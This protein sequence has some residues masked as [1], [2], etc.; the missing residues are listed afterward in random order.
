MLLFS[1]TLELLIIP[2][3]PFFQQFAESLVYAFRFANLLPKFAIC[4]FSKG[5]MRI[6]PSISPLGLLLP[7]GLWPGCHILCL[8]IVGV[9]NGGGLFRIPP[10]VGSL[11]F[12]DNG[13]LGLYFFFMGLGVGVGYWWKALLRRS[14]ALFQFRDTFIG[15]LKLGW[16]LF[17]RLP[18]ILVLGSICLA[19][20][21]TLA[22]FL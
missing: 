18:D 3:L 8:R 13:G 15:F 22:S 2:R 21:L 5:V 6:P 17:N 9:P 4:F 20:M 7:S 1:F 11:T 14:Y 16:G 10:I 19:P 12:H